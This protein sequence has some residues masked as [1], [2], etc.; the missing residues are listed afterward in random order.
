MRAVSAPSLSLSLPERLTHLTPNGPDTL[1][2]TPSV[3][4]RHKLGTLED[5]VMWP[6]LP[7]YYI[8]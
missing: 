8:T 1:D 2:H 5:A 4:G 6:W 7:Q 3:A